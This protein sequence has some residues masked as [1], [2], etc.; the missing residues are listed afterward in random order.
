MDSEKK[1]L[2]IH[3]ITAIAGNAKRNHDFYTQVLGLRLVKKTVNFD[4]PNTYHFYFADEVGTPGTILTFFPWEGVSP[5]KSGTGLATEISYSVPGKSLEFWKARLEKNNVQVIGSGTRLGEHFLSFL[6]PDGLCLTFIIPKTIDKRKPWTTAAVKA[7]VATRGFHSITLTLRNISA[8]AKVLTEIFEYRALAQEGHRFR[9][10][11]NTVENAAIIDLVE[12]PE[13]TPGVNA[14]G[15]IHHIA[16]RVKDEDVLMSFREKIVRKGYSITPKIDRNYFF[17]LY[18]REPGGV[19]FELA[20][21]NPGF[22]IDEKVTE[23]GSTLRLP[24]QYEN[25]R[26]EIEKVLPA[27]A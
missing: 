12:A 19:L 11:T 25:N 27:L 2:G 10:V 14:G 4:D 21:D 3:H 24:S 20:T 6:D 5:G 1:I 23:L 7:D 17:S 22:A 9:Y 26:A 18:F 16:F 15:T 13:L 8:T